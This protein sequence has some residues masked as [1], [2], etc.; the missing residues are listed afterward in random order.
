MITAPMGT[1]FTGEAMPKIPAA[2]S[3]ML[4]KM[5]IDNP[6]TSRWKKLEF[7]DYYPPHCSYFVCKCRE[8][9]ERL[10]LRFAWFGKRSTFIAQC[11]YCR[12]IYWRDAL[13]K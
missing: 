4:A 7:P 13:K 5:Y 9:N 6:E 3:E 1:V 8:G 2:Y 12:V 11:P 10:E